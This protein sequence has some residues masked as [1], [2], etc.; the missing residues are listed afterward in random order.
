[1][2]ARTKYRVWILGLM[3]CLSI[4]SVGVRRASGQTGPANDDCVNAEPISD[5]GVFA[6]DNRLAVVD[7]P[8]HTACLYASATQVDHD[9]WFCWTAPHTVCPGGYIVE[10]CSRTAVDTRLAV[11]DG[12]VCPPS[13]A[14]LLECSDDDC[15]SEGYQTRVSIAAVGGQQYL[16]RVGTYPGMQGGTGAINIRCSGVP[17]NDNCANAEPIAGEGLFDFDSSLAT[18]DGNPH[19]DCIFAYEDQIIQDIWFCWEAPCNGTVFAETCDLTG[20]DTKVAIYDECAC[21]AFDENLLSC[22]DDRCG[23]G[24]FYLQS[25]TTFE[26]IAGQNYL[27]RVG[28]WPQAADADS[29]GGPGSLRLTCGRDACPGTGNCFEA[30]G[31]TGCDDESCCEKVCEIDSVCC[32]VGWDDYCRREAEGLCGGQFSACAQPGTLDCDLENTIGG[33]ADPDCCNAV[34]TEDPYCCLDIWDSSCAQAEPII[35]RTSCGRGAGGCL[36]GNGSPGCQIEQCCTEVCQRD[37]FCCWGLSSWDGACATMAATYCGNT[38]GCPTGAV[39]WIDPPDGV[40]DAR[41]PA[42]SSTGL[43][44]G[45]D[46][47]LVEAPS[48][49]APACFSLCE[50]LDRGSPNAIVEVHEGAPEGGV[51]VYTI[52][53]AR[54]ITPA[55]ITTITYTDD[56]NARK[57]AQFAAHPAN[58]NGD[59]TAGAPDVLAMIDFLNGVAVEFNAPWGRYSV[60]VDHSGVAGAPDV[61]AVIDLL[62]GAS[63]FDPWSNTPLP[64][65]GGICP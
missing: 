61:L 3:C 7:G 40:V 55:A 11:Y 37:P 54:P 15:G 24:P 30:N 17:G 65:I 9:V 33:C 28:A 38:P 19:T 48:G 23:S 2:N 5:V 44:L 41:Y 22:N 6:F 36:V 35:C 63:V 58:V 4:T 26:A 8:S 29:R 34:C 27:V 62:N 59:S 53:L 31:T 60:D 49:A 25:R 10:T 57:T 32:D 47:F 18:T 13:D 45:I 16:I 50:T 39:H 14:A 46:T 42:D 12:C 56:H 20:V 52:G 51:S 21:P 64:T 43:A 1:M